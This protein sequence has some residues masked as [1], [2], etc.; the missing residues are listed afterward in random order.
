MQLFE[1]KIDKLVHGGQGIGVLPDG[2]KVFVWGVL[3]GERV[4]VRL[5]K[6]RR[7]YAEGIA[8]K[9]LD[10]DRADRIGQE[11][12]ADE[13]LATQPWHILDWTAELEAK[14]DITREIYEREGVK[15]PE[16]ELQTFG[17]LDGYR[18]KME[19]AFWGDEDGLSLAHYKR[20]SHGK[21]KIRQ[22]LLA[23]DCVNT[24]GLTLIDVLNKHGI[25]A[26]Q[27]KSV[28]IRGVMPWQTAI[29]LFVK[30]ENFP[31]LDFPAGTVVYYSNP[32]SPASVPTKELYRH[33]DTSLTQLVLDRQLTYDVLSFF[34]VNVPIFEKAL[35]D[36]Q[37]HMLPDMPVVDMYAGVGTIGLALGRTPL[38]VVEIDP[39]NVMMAEKNAAADK[40]IEI[41]QASTEQAFDHIIPD[42][43]LILDP[44]R[45][46]L[47]KKVVEKIQNSQPRQ[48][49]YLSCNPAT[50]A[51]D[52][53]KLLDTYEL[54][55][56]GAYNFFPRTPHIE[57]LAVLSKK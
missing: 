11:V 27:L 10:S 53:A 30:D 45:S 34:Q 12:V 31:R 9:I 2:R 7:D 37:K 20:G 28:I 44:P 29:A 19:Y 41:I 55:F 43:C 42:S 15:L 24:A 6:K 52:V 51:R 21:I 26:S 25:R 57:S 16:F 39:F 54:A 47:H 38:K 46:G 4:S 14:K 22:S 3:P 33:G 40:N 17:S 50:Q 49:M 18:N 8:E 5:T 1:V 48:V 56:F 35:Q 13:M 36:M 32:K 23:N